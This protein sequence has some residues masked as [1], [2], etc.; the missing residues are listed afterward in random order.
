MTARSDFLIFDDYVAS[1]TSGTVYVFTPDSLN[2]A[3][4]SYDVIAC[5]AV[6]DNVS[7]SGSGSFKLYLQHSADDRNFV[8]SNGTTTP[9]GTPE[10]SIAS[11][12]TTSTNFGITAYQGTY[13]LLGN[14]RFAFQFG[15]STTSAHVKLFVAQRDLA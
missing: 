9:P 14:V 3:L 13:P 11:L 10:I 6:V 4:G 8:F 12:S 7:V 2:D 1:G 15:E 5:E